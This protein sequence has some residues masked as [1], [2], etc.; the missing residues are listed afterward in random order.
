M[1]AVSDSPPSIWDAQYRFLL[2]G[3]V[4]LVTVVAFE[5]M[6]I[7]TV[8]PVVEDDL[9][10]LWLYGWV[11]SA[12]YLG[13]LIGVVA[14][15]HSADKTR[16]VVP[17]MLG[18]G[19]FL[20]GLLVGG[21]APTMPVLVFGRLL[22]GVGAG[23]VSAVSYVCVGRGFPAVLH[24]AV[25]AVMSTAW[26]VP[27][28]VSPLMASVIADQ[29]GWRWVFLGLIPLT[30]VVALVGGHAV[31]TIDA[32]AKTEQNKAETPIGRVVILAIGS[33]L[34]LGGLGMEMIWIGLIIALAGV[35][36]A[37][38]AFTRL[39][40][41]GTLAARPRLPAAVLI[42]GALT[43]SF[44]AADTFISLSL[45]SVRGEST[46]YAGVVL[47][48]STATWTAGSWLQAHY[49]RR[50]GGGRMVGLG[51][52]AQAIGAVVLAL[53]L[54]SVVPVWCWIVGSAIMGLGMGM[55]YTMLS[56]VTLD[57]A[58][59]G[60]EGE[61]SSALQM[62]DILGVALGAG[63]AG[64]LVSL[65]D[66]MDLEPWVALA[67]VFVMAALM[68]AAV[69]LLSPRLSRAVAGSDART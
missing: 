19:L 39:T 48:F 6:A 18:I 11:F 43:F 28:L 49:G 31:A 3:V 47:I 4:C 60:S 24:P 38:P 52:L 26:V 1:S 30:V 32:P 36:I 61:A 67:A 68:G 22:Q 37:L 34:L 12:F 44:F 63:L 59:I 2:A 25:F 66:R 35:L 15:G 65:G 50:M 10:D 42:R 13:T 5:A 40:P 29:V 20:V 55:A 41:P 62:S 51:G 7:S 46:I 53:S 17:M 45:T 33:A 27:S 64:V 23:V 57:E 8:M 58:A 14:G 9:G 56:V 16:P 21:L 54:W 69:L